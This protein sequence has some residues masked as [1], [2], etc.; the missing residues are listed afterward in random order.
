MTFYILESYLLC[1]KQL[2][3]GWRKG[4]NCIK[5]K[6]V[7]E[8]QKSILASPLIRLPEWSCRHL[9]K[10]GNGKTTLQ[11]LKITQVF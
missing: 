2:A 1:A 10:T 7:T 8:I 11:T 4:L 9:E 6:G 3:E 5:S